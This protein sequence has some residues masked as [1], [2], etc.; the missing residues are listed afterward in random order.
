MQPDELSL[1]QRR[2]LR[3]IAADE[4]AAVP[5]EVT[6]RLDPVA[7]KRRQ[8]DLLHLEQAGMVTAKSAE[9][10]EL[11]AE[12][13]AAAGLAALPRPSEFGEAMR[14]HHRELNRELVRRMHACP[15]AFFE[16][17]VV[18]LLR[19]MGYGG[20]HADLCRRIGRSRDGGIDGVVDRD[21]LELDTLYV[22]AKRYA[23]GTAV[24]LPD[25]R[26]FAGTLD[27]H[28]AVKG[29]FLT[30][31]HFST[32]ALD[33]C[34][35]LTRRVALIDGTR[36]ADLLIR[37]GLGVR[38]METWQIRTIDESYFSPRRSAPIAD[39]SSASIQPRR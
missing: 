12:G 25:L 27:M 24:P 30:T 33:F 39:I 26:D 36:L 20:R 10:Y 28:R 4:D 18:D 37:Y 29:V 2:L 16:E 19:T 7:L 6:P 5:R 38:T 1:S 21:E 3:E 22:Q 14:R 13:R 31:A 34:R 11:T 32:A 17:L 35:H 8:W 23:P 9:C 15:P